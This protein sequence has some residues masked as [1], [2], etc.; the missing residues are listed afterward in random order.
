M[1][2][3][4]PKTS[5]SKSKYHHYTAI[6]YRGYAL[7]W[8]ILITV[9]A[10]FIALPFIHVD[11]SVQSRGTITTLNKMVQ[12]NSPVT[13]KVTAVNIS[14]NKNVRC[15]DT[16]IVLQ[17]S[18]FINEIEL[19]NQQM[20]LQTNYID[21]ISSLLGHIENANV[22]TTLYQKEYEDYTTSIKM[23]RRK[24]DKLGVDFKRTAAL[25]K[26]G[27]V[28]LTTYQEDSFKLEEARDELMMYISASNARWETDRR[29][30][31]VSNQELKSK[32]ENLWQERSQ[33][34]LTA[35]FDGS[36]IDFNGVAVGNFLTESQLIAYLSPQQELIAECYISP[37][38]IGFIH[39]DMP[40]RLQIDTYDY[41]Q[42]GMLDAVV[43]E[44]ADDVSLV[45]GQYKYLI[46][47]H[48]KQDSLKLSNGVVGNM[49]KGMSL[50]GRFIVTQRSLFHLLFDTVDDW[51]NP[52]VLPNEPS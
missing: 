3:N 5:Q 51:L 17:Q 1:P 35:P 15:G 27:V 48:L 9:F 52:K 20:E 12:L 10:G 30:Y 26:D 4:T 28:P 14:E 37:S 25:F 49:K 36:I 39:T 31:I 32:V 33:Y 2:V 40:V 41:N 22:N 47:C 43:F 8:V 13:A 11:V 7:Y 18:G 16:L 44:V 23:F 6:N 50:T 38:D 34:L 46:R 24:I 29:N 45:D 19:V 42:W 21:D